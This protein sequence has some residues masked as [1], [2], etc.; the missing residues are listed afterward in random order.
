ME[1]S[2][3]G[4]ASDSL[5]RC[6]NAWTEGSHLLMP[7]SRT[8]CVSH[9]H[10]P[11]ATSMSPRLLRETARTVPASSRMSL[12]PPTR[13]IL[14]AISVRCIDPLRRHQPPPATMAPTTEGRSTASVDRPSRIRRAVQIPTCSRPHV[15]ST[16]KH[17]VHK[18]LCPRLIQ[19][20]SITLERTLLG[21]RSKLRTCRRCWTR[22]R[23]WRQPLTVYAPP[24][25]GSLA[26]H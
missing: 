26:S 23:M 7:S 3:I 22:H 17:F 16:P 13:S 20:T 9:T 12:N 4:A 10:T 2:R 21:S 6:L 24:L 18:R 14:I 19:S 5:W 15:G 8:R 25:A 1:Q 11:K